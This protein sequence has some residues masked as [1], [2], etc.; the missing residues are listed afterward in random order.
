MIN[1]N[2]TYHATRI[3]RAHTDPIRRA[4]AA[5]YGTLDGRRGPH[6]TLGFAPS[7]LEWRMMSVREANRALARD[8]H[9][10]TGRPVYSTVQDASVYAGRVCDWYRT[11]GRAI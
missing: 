7:I 2:V 1:L 4:R 3:S 6:H 9:P 10:Q 5:R 8:R 11:N